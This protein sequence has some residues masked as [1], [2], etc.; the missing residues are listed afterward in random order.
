[1]SDPRVEALAAV[2]VDYSIGAKA[3]QQITIEAPAVAAPLIREVYRRILKAGAYP[4]PRIGI[5]GMVENLMLDG[6]DEQLDWVNPARRDDIESV[7]GR[8]VI[9]APNNTRSLTSVDAAKQ[10]RLHRALEPQRNRYLE[11]AAAGDLS[12]VLTLFPT[13]GAAQDAEMSLPEYEDFVYAAGFLDRDDPV[14]EW[15][16][17]GGLLDR[18]GAFLE[19]VSELRIVA[20]DTDLRIGVGGRQ[21]IRSRGL[22]NFPDGE[23]FTGPVETS[24]EGT[25]HFTYP[26]IFQGREVDDVRLR[27]EA[28]EVV[29]ASASRG[30][31]LLREMIT[32]DD[33]ARRAGEFA[34][35]LNDAVTAFTREI[36]FDEKIGGTVHLALG[37][38]YPATGSANRSALHWDLI[39]DLR[40]GGEVYADGELCYRDGAFLG[41]V[42]S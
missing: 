33:G 3:G 37:T 36:L 23:I 10:A 6:S 2:L 1:V 31:D 16:A 20:E 40:N 38:A 39:C 25:I 42:L 29:E 15:K 9:M 19:G 12:W 17:F 32:V 7:D 34:F 5:E 28:G 22:E 14:A 4:L 35:G 13:Q 21:W 8:V 30:E 18:V 41:S 11:R 27:F 26:A 24:V